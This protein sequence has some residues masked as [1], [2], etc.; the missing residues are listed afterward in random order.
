M[1][2]NPVYAIKRKI[3]YTVKVKC[4]E[5]L[6]LLRIASW[7][8]RYSPGF[9]IIGGQK[10][11][12]SSLYNYLAQHPQLIASFKKEIHYFDNGLEPCQQNYA[13]GERWYRAFF[14][15]ITN[16]NAIAFE[17]S[18]MYCFNPETA[19]RIY[20]FNPDIK[21]IFC[22]RN[23]KARAISHYYHEVKNKREKLPLL[24]AMETEDVRLQN[25]LQKRDYHDPCFKNF[26]YKSRGLYAEQLKRFLKYFPE[27]QIHIVCAEELFAEPQQALEAIYRFVGVDDT[28]RS[29]NLR[30]VNVSPIKKEVDAATSKHLDDFF[31]QPN[32]EFFDLIGRSFNWNQDFE[33][34]TS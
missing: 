30:P 18:P 1:K 32:I 16:R 19:Q 34:I 26:S 25:A 3:P 17:A 33:K 29:T 2:L 9:I 7:K 8:K 24:E 28:F 6:H 10:C 23:P 5:L 27:N 13:K 11:G 20:Q 22:I 31:Q 21:I 14:P 4:K 12:T 15:I